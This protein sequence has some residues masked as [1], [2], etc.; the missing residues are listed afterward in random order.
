MRAA[1]CYYS[2][3]GS[4]KQYAEWIAQA[5]N[6]PLV[7]IKRDKIDFDAF[8]V[9]I[10]GSP[11][12]YYKL[13]AEEWLERHEERLQDKTIIIFSVAVAP[14]GEKPEEWTEERLPEIFKSEVELFYLRGKQ[15]PK[16]MSIKHRLA[17]ITAEMLNMDAEARK[18]EMKGLSYMDKK[19]I[20]PIVEHI[21][22]LEIQ[23]RKD[24]GDFIVINH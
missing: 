16:D 1:I 22:E 10:I 14:E 7:D 24:A 8:D 17:I 20:K 23:S 6:L 13:A 4:T 18:D 5:T 3:Y 9:L 12:Y 15:V 2:Y 19:T 11:I 21:K